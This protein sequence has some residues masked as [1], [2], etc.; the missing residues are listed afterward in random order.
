MPSTSEGNRVIRDGDADAPTRSS[1]NGGRMDRHYIFMTASLDSAESQCIRFR[2]SSHKLPRRPGRARGL[3]RPD[4]ARD[5]VH[6]GRP[7]ADQDWP[8]MAVVQDGAAT[9]ARNPYRNN[10][11]PRFFLA[12]SSQPDADTSRTRAGA[13]SCSTPEGFGSTRSRMVSNFTSACCTSSLARGNSQGR[14]HSET[15]SNY[16]CT[17]T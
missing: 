1:Q 15:S 5:A 3:A 9:A 10:R 7:F 13:G 2:T 14:T 16:L 11:R 6:L 8:D 17:S 12:V 4:G